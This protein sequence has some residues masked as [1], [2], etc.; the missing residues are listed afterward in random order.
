MKSAHSFSPQVYA[1]VGGIAYLV[2]IVFGLLGEMFVRNSL[3]VSGNAAA[4]ANNIAASSG[5]WR[6]GIAGDLIMHI[7]DV[8]LMVV[9]YV[10]L[11]PVNRN[12]ALMAVLFNVV[13]TSVLVSNKMNLLMPTFLLNGAGY[14]KAYSLEQ[15]QAYSYLFLRAHGYGFGV[16]LIF[17]GCTCVLLGY[18][19]IKSGYFPKWIGVL[20]QIAGICYLFNSFSLIL[21]PKFAD[22]LFPFI[23]LPP[24]V[25]ELSLCICLIVKGVNMEKWNEKTA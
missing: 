24:F 3:I 21:A 4:T 2:I 12:L 9:F 1:R 14:L 8:I 10:L 6:A 18:L 5:L 22:Q 13:Q 17:F 7:C 25:G 20:M 16:G 15:L 19:I 23:L 11:K